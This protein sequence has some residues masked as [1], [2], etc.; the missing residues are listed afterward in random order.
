MDE[1]SGE[2]MVRGLMA[3]KV[4]YP[5][6]VMSGYLTAEVVRGWFPGDPRIAFLKKPF[7]PNEF[8]AEL[9]KHFE[10]EPARSLMN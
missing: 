4:S 8:Y 7:A 6:L 2:E 1:M 5:I 3:Q 10:P 9:E